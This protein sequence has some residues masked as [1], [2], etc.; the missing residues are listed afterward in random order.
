MV[1]SASPSGAVR[2]RTLGVG[3]ARYSTTKPRSMVPAALT[4][5]EPTTTD[6]AGAAVLGL[7][8]ASTLKFVF[9]TGFITVLYGTLTNPVAPSNAV[10][11]S[12]A[13]GPSRNTP[14]A[15]A[16]PP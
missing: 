13:S 14:L 8:H 15:M 12:V 5:Y 1:I 6:R 3:P 16:T 11:R 4:R 2:A 10:A 9:E 7:I